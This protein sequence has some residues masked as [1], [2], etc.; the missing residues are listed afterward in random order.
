MNNL[1]SP[2]LTG[3]VV[4]CGVT[5]AKFV[6]WEILF[7]RACGAC[8]KTHKTCTRKRLPKREGRRVT[9][10]SELWPI[11]LFHALLDSL[12]AK[13]VL[14][15]PPLPGERTPWLPLHPTLWMALFNQKKSKKI[16]GTLSTASRVQHQSSI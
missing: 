12:G 10:F 11:N 16:E 1:W 13:G 15:A 7:C 9:E 3:I 4:G 5:E 8:N 2:V 14:S 6:Y